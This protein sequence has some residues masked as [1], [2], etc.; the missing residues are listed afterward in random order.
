M[1]IQWNIERYTRKDINYL[2]ALGGDAGFDLNES[3]RRPS[4]PEIVPFPS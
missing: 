3:E 2:E 1:F 4:D